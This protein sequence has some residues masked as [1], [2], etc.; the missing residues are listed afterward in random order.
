MSADLRT[1][2]LQNLP[3]AIRLMN[4]SSRGMSFE[5]NLDLFS[6]LALLRYWDFSYEYSLIGYVQDEPAALI[7]NCANPESHEAYTVYWGA[8][9]KFRTQRIS[10]VLFNTCCKKMRDDGYFMLHGVSVPD[11]PVRRYRFIQAQPERNL[12]DMEA[13]S[14][15]L[16]AA[17][18]TLEVREIDV[19]ALAQF[20]LAAGEFLH[21]SQRHAF[22]RNVAPF[23]QILGAFSGDILKAY[24]VALPRS[25]NTT[26]TDLR[27][28]DSDLSAGYELLRWLVERNY[29]PPFTVN[30]V[31]EQSYAHRVLTSAGFSVKRQFSTLTRD[32]RA[33]A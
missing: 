28:T 30:Y 27:S 31:L 26:L 15:N 16:P 21:W 13:E 7:I 18:P 8:L 14:P 6:F 25:P 10:L 29:R 17:D 20:P 4:E 12:V 22:L 1:I 5:W 32:L 11:R 24:A 3:D 33:T 19:E 2:N 23:Q 9:P